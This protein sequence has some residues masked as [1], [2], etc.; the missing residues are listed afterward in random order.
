[1]LILKREW[2]KVFDALVG[3]ETNDCFVNEAKKK[4]L[5]D[6][7]QVKQA[8]RDIP[9]KYKIERTLVQGYERVGMKGNFLQ[10]LSFLNR[11]ARNLYC[12][13][14]QSYLWNK[15]AS[16]RIL[17]HGKILVKGDIVAKRREAFLDVDEVEEEIIDEEF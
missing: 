1:M 7:T 13:A 2:E 10:A 9:F 4:F 16:H 3:Q 8:L 14:Y 12:H 11:N 6:K 15:L 17:T 5:A